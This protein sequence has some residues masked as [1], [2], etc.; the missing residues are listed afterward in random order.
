MDMS[1]EIGLCLKQPSNIMISGPTGCGKTVF[2]GK[3]LAQKLLDP[4]PKRI[5]V[6]YGEWQKAY[7]QWR[8]WYPHIEFIHGFRD[9]LINLFNPK[10]PNLLIIDDQMGEAGSSKELKALF[11]RGSHHR[12]LT[13]VYIVQ[14]LF[15]QGS[16]MRTVSL[17]AQ[18]IVLF[19]NPRDMAQLETLGRLMFPR[20]GKYLSD[21]LEMLSAEKAF[22]PLIINMRSDTP[23]GMPRAYTGVFAGESLVF[24]ESTKQSGGGKQA[25]ASQSANEDASVL[26]L[27]ELSDERDLFTYKPGVGGI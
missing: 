18:Y 24:F 22:S 15:D 5:V 9:D 7:E 11:T 17:N 2:V 25:S 12:N 10:S 26:Q 20:N 19:K 3:F 23:P 27:V 14:N 4:W 1:K 16:A 13:I 21:L 6:V 8:Q